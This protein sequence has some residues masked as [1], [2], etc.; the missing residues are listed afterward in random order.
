MTAT[1]AGTDARTGTRIN[2][3]V[4]LLAAARLLAARRD[5]CRPASPAALA[6]RLIPGY[7]IT[8]T[9]ALISDVL[10]DAVEH[11]DRRVIVSTPPRSGKSVL[12]SQVAPVFTLMGDP[13][14]E[15]I[16]KSYADE[17]AEEHSRE[18][19]RLIADDAGLLGIELA[20]DK[21][22]VGRW[23]VQGR[24]GGLLA[25][26]I[27]SG[28]TGFGADLLIVDDPVKGAAEADPPRSAVA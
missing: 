8:P 25:G 17:L 12:A 11:P 1:V 5:R 22:S 14:A 21:S 9:V 3:T 26:G 27:L 15:V 18:A 28:T 10:A 6:K 7:V 2:N 19:R 24:R 13:D 16:V 23:R 20:Q 4:R